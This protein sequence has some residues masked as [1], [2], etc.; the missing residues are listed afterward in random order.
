M[1]DAARTSE[2]TIGGELAAEAVTKVRDV[3]GFGPF[4]DG[5]VLTAVEFVQRLWR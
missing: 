2:R 4:L 5:F 3:S 1:R